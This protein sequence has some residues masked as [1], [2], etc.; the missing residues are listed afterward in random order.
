MNTTAPPPL[1]DGAAL[2]AAKAIRLVREAA[3]KG[4]KLTYAEAVARAKAGQPKT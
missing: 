4:Q 2:L 1:P 3:A